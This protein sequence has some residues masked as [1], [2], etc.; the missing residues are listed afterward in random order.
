[1][2]RSELNSERRKRKKGGR[3][4]IRLETKKQ[5]QNQGKQTNKTLNTSHPNTRKYMSAEVET[6]TCQVSGEIQVP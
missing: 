4:E 1:V 6:T 2:E 3:E 5:K